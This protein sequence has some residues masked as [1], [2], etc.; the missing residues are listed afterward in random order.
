MAARAASGLPFPLAGSGSTAAR[1]AG[2][3]AC[4]TAAR[5][6]AVS[7]VRRTAP[8]CTSAPST[9][10]SRTLK[11]P[12]SERTRKRTSSPLACT[13]SFLTASA[14]T[15]PLCGPVMR[16]SDRRRVYT[17]LM[18]SGAGCTSVRRLRFAANATSPASPCR[19]HRARRSRA[20]SPDTSFS[21]RVR[22]ELPTPSSHRSYAGARWFE[23]RYSAQAV[24][25]GARARRKCRKLVSVYTGRKGLTSS[26]RAQWQAAIASQPP[27]CTRPQGPRTVHGQR[28]ITMCQC[29]RG[30][31]E[32]S[33]YQS[34]W[35]SELAA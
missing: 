24:S 6:S 18:M 8:I 21:T 14:F 19:A 23:R 5:P 10:F 29:L 4:N 31:R 17:S 13:R 30:R 15:F 33:P 22:T 35:R 3:A 34:R 16:A 11:F 32:E 12:M 28:A 26:E 27:E 2:D 20:C 9:N 7:N 1:S 25:P